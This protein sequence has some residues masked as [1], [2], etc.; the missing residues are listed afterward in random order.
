MKPSIRNLRLLP[1]NSVVDPGSTVYS[2]TV[3]RMGPTRHW[4]G[5]NDVHPLDS[6]VEVILLV[7][8]VGYTVQPNEHWSTEYNGML[9]GRRDPNYG[10]YGRFA[11]YEEP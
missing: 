1:S 8:G 9:G 3:G 11:V 7:S 4:P 2:V 10:C 6:S 5:T